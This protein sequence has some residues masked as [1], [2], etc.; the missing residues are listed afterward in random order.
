MVIHEGCSSFL[1]L[2]YIFLDEIR[3]KAKQLVPHYMRHLWIRGGRGH[4]SSLIVPNSYIKSS[5]MPQRFLSHKLLRSTVIMQ[6][7]CDDSED[8]RYIRS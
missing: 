5:R 6:G 4:D 7:G 3:E 2:M 8:Q 1:G